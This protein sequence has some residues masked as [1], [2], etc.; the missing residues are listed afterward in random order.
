MVT[1]TLCSVNKYNTFIDL[2]Y[3]F[4]C[5]LSHMQKH[6]HGSKTQCRTRTS[7]QQGLALA[8]TAAGLSRD[9]TT[10]L[11]YNVLTDKEQ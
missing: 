4:V 6:R 7:L 2:L 1:Y 5:Q 9:N 3:N 11:Q 10:A 8:A